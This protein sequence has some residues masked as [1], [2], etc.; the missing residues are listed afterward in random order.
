MATVTVVEGDEHSRRRLARILMADGMEVVEAESALEAL[1]TAFQQPPHAAVIDL[2]T[3]GLEGVELIRI[4]RAACDI[5]IVVIARSHEPQE[6][7]K[8]L[9]AGADD[10]INAECS[11]VEL[12]ARLRGAM[13]RYGK[14]EPQ[15]KSQA[16]ISTGSLI[17]DMGAQT[18]QKR[19][20]II[21][22]TRTEHRLLNALATRIGET[23]PHRELLTEAWGYQYG[24]DTQY[25][26]LYVGY[27]RA[28]L[29]DEPGR[30]SYIVNEWGVGYRLARL[31]IEQ[32]AE[33]LSESMLTTAAG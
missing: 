10:V 31:P 28:K 4:L 14:R 21:P 22:L 6:V 19:G 15:A 17:I 7:V 11:P 12:L 16:R 2:A 9:D 1:R 30:P 18:V 5:P 32:N 27:L 13:R 26:R 8:S 23:V 25:L 20:R 3:P 24:D 33:A 29:E